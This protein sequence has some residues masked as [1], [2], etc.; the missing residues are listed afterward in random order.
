MDDNFVF[1]A[2]LFLLTPKIEIA[3]TDGLFVCFFVY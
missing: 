3:D 1:S 2:S